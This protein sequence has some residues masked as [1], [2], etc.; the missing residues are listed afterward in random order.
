MPEIRSMYKVLQSRP[1]LS[2]CN[3]SVQVKVKVRVRVKVKVRDLYMEK[4]FPPASETADNL[5][6][7]K[8]NRKPS[9]F[10]RKL[11]L[12]Y[13]ASPQLVIFHLFILVSCTYLSISS[14][15]FLKEFSTELELNHLSCCGCE[16]ISESA[17]FM[18]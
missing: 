14:P 17:Q 12:H 9:S 3:S 18:K 13:A 7:P 15:F 1:T 11:S 16:H 6:K 2:I 4:R 10:V 5:E 8:D